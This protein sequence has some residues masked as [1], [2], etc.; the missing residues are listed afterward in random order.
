MQDS[1]ADLDTRAL[2]SYV[3]NDLVAR[4][5]ER[6]H[7]NLESEVAIEGKGARTE[8]GRYVYTMIEHPYDVRLSTSMQ[9]SC[10]ENRQ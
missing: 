1:E 8:A 3:E 9:G 4:S 7:G 10:G 5:P 2:I 6:N